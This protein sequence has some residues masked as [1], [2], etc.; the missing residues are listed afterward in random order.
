MREFPIFVDGEELDLEDVEAAALLAGV[1]D[2]A[3]HLRDTKIVVEGT[4]R[5]AWIVPWHEGPIVIGNGATGQVYVRPFT[6]YMS[7]GGATTNPGTEDASGGSEDI[8]NVKSAFWPGGAISVPVPLPTA[9]NARWDFLYAIITET[10]S[11]SAARVVRDPVTTARGTQTIFTRHKAT[12][13]L[14]F[15]QGTPGIA[16]NPYPAASFPAVPAPIAG[17]A[18]SPLAAIR[19]NFSATPATV[20]YGIDDIANEPRLSRPNPQEGSIVGGGASMGG[21]ADGNPQ[22]TDI[23]TLATIPSN[24]WPLT[25]SNVRPSSFIE[26]MAGGGKRWIHLGPFV[27]TVGHETF[28]TSWTILTATPIFTPAL[29]GGAPA[30]VAIHDDDPIDWAG[31]WFFARMVSGDTAKSA[32]DVTADRTSGHLPGPTN[33]GPFHVAGN[34]FRSNQVMDAAFGVAADTWGYAAVFTD[35]L[36]TGHSDTAIALLVK[37]SDGALYLAGRANAADIATL[38]NTTFLILLDYSPSFLP[39]KLT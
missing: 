23:T 20:T 29:A 21:Q 12:V 38:N 25:G 16:A 36:G 3:A 37:F 35:V 7:P 34:S 19:V 2:D 30:E 1:A 39:K 8:T 22:P 27:N 10:D 24:A 17:A 13:T 15:I 26:K 33:H 14:A 11:G 28:G 4:N 18:H 31:R 6:I 32:H 5:K 9:G